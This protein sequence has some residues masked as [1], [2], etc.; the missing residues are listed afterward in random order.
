MRRRDFIAGLGGTA[1]W[2][3]WPLAARA[4]QPAIP[5]V[6]L[7]Q[8]RSAETAMPLTAAFRQGLRD[9]GFIEG[10]NVAIEYRFA[11]AEF[12]RLPALAA[13]LVSRRVNVIAVGYSAARAAQAATATIPIVFMG[14]ADPVKGGVVASINRPGGNVTGASLLADVLG[15][16]RMGLLREIVP[17]ISVVGA[18]IEMGDSADQAK[19]LKEAARSLGW[20][21]HTV[22]VDTERNFEDAFARLVR[23]G[24]GAI[25]ITPSVLFNTYPDRLVALAAR[26]RVPAIYE[27]REFVV[28]GGLMSYA[29]SITDA[30]RQGGVYAGRVLKG[31][32]PADMPV[33]LPTKFEFV[34]NLKTARALGLT[35]PPGIL[36]I[37]DDVIE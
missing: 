4:Q 30:Y 28:A 35:I 18:L 14:G 15:P 25:I 33:L 23:E 1:V 36:A 16:K 2:S 29:P 26:H 20:S 7:L 13:E 3:T 22:E 6:G 12:N 10:Q 19:E 31:E 27:L 11:A 17:Q 5:V 32:K 21:V 34:L 37:A 9:A 24:A 8:T